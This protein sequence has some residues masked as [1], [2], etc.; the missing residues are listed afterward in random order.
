MPATE[1]RRK[2]IKPK[3]KSVWRSKHS[4]SKNKKRASAQTLSFKLESMHPSQGKLGALKTPDS[5]AS[6]ESAGSPSLSSKENRMDID[7]ECD[8]RL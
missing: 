6:V 5:G 3:I 7:L 2:E 4:I 8:E 1:Q